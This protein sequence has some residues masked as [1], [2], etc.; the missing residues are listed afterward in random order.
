MVVQLLPALVKMASHTDDRPTAP[1]EQVHATS[2]EECKVHVT[3]G[4]EDAV[5][6]FYRTITNQ[7]QE[8]PDINPAVAGLEAYLQQ[9][10]PDGVPPLPLGVCF[11][12]ITTYG[13][14]GGATP[15]KTLKDAIWRTLTFQDIYEWTFKRIISPSKIEDGHALIRDFSGVVKNGQMMLQVTLSPM[16]LQDKRLIVSS[17]LG[18]PG[19]GCSTFL[20]TIANDHASFLG[21]GGSLSYSGLSPQDISK[22]FRGLVTYVPEDD[23]HL[24]T[25][26]V[27]QTLEFALQNKTPRKW[28]HRT[29]HFVEEFGKAFG[30]THVMDTL[31]GNE[32]IRGVS[33]GERKRVSILE[34]LASDASINAWDGS[35]RG[36]DASSALDFIRSLRIMTD[37][38]QRATIVSLYQ[39]SDAIYQL[40]DKVMLID[41]GRMLYNGPAKDA[42]AYFNDLGYRRLPRQTMSDFLTSITSGSTANIAPGY[43][44]H[45]P[46]GASNLESAFR[47]SQAFKAVES[48]IRDFETQFPSPGASLSN[49]GS[50]TSGQ[51][52]TSTL[53]EVQQHEK[54]H[55]SRLVSSKS[56]YHTSLFR[57]VVLCA[58]REYWQLKGH[59]TPFV[60]KIICVVVCAFLLSSMFY[61]MPDDT[62]GVYSRGGFIFYS[63]AIVAWFQ[64]SELETAFRDRTIVSRQR[65]YAMVRPSAVVCGKALLDVPSLLI[66]STVYSVIAYFLAGMRLAVSNPS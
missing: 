5:A 30:M 51:T 39:A 29:A 63:T 32:F 40:M 56:P 50:Q 8:S 20:R 17:V 15:V 31:V 13:R 55:K 42:E 54:K 35:T 52:S 9:E 10:Q 57:Q 34:S 27:R 19:S 36:L 2:E 44:A 49:S 12:S 16:Q 18:N 25:L 23:I 47:K 28:L 58:Q 6:R 33:G 66:L 59:K 43:E 7:S 45:V 60:F 21:V 64:M 65:R 46:L 11:K 1:V 53:R 26:T 38:C 3:P 4:A 14:P 48:E 22:R 37:S 24:P 41:E 62:S 61:N